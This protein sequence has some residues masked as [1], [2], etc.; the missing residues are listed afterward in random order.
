MGRPKG[1]KNKR[2]MTVEMIASRYDLDPFDILMMVAT[3]DWRG[4]GFQNKTKSTFTMNGIEVEEENINNC[5]ILMIW[6]PI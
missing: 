3:G 6:V 5:I 1:A 2:S 4:L